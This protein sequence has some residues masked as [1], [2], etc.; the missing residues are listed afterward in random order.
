[1]YILALIVIGLKLLRKEKIVKKLLILFVIALATMAL[2]LSCGKKTE[3]DTGK[4]P[5]AVKKAETIDSTRM[6]SAVEA[7]D[8]TLSDTTVSEKTGE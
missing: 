1:M 2:I 3:E 6:D 8:T 4:T 7:T 5:P